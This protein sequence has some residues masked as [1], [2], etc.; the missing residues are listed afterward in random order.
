[1][2]VIRRKLELRDIG[3]S[4]HTGQDKKCRILFLFMHLLDLFFI[5]HRFCTFVRVTVL[6]NPHGR[7]YSQILC[8]NLFPFFF[9]KFSNFLKSFRL[10]RSFENFSKNRLRRDDSFGPKIVEI[11]AILAI[12]RL[13][14]FFSKI[15]HLRLDIYSV[16]Y[17]FR[18]TITGRHRRAIGC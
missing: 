7:K 8:S 18:V 16:R 14:D 12:F 13:F 2:D 11:G 1:M 3:L 4:C 6:R 10:F 15:F 9:G 17:L 5:V